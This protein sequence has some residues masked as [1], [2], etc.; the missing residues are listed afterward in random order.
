MNG[1]EE[2]EFGHV[3]DEVRCSPGV[4]STGPDHVVNQALHRPF[5]GLSVDSRRVGSM[6]MI[7]SLTLFVIRRTG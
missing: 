3:S 1:R 2:S 4:E 6:M 5:S 7:T